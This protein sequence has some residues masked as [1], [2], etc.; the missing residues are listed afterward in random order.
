MIAIPGGMN[1]HHMP[2]WSAAFETAV[3]IIRPSD[4]TCD[5]PRPR[6]SSVAAVRTEPPKSRMKVRKRYELMFGAI[7]LT[8]TRTVPRPERRA[9]LTKSR[10]ASENVC[11]RIA[12]AAQGHEVSPIRIASAI[13]LPT[14]R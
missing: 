4:I 14:L 5:G 11:A 9:R 8:I 6:K 12:R 10:A 3:F 13:R 2:S 1:H 7:S